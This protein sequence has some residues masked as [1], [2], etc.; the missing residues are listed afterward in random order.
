MWLF[1]NTCA[2][3]NHNNG[4][5]IILLMLLTYLHIWRSVKGNGWRPLRTKAFGESS[6]ESV[7]PK[8]SSCPFIQYSLKSENLCRRARCG[9]QVNFKANNAVL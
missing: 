7:S 8:G 2:V 9:P 3:Q 6:T 1:W 5:K 4:N